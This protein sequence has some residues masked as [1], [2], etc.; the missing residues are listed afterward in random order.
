[1]SGSYVTAGMYCALGS[2][3]TRINSY[4]LYLEQMSAGSFIVI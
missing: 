4:K 2:K 1:M 3:K